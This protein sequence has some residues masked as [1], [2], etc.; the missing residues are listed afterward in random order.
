MD[1]A[2]NRMIL[3]KINK[4]QDQILKNNHD[5]WMCMKDV[6]KYTKLS[7]STIRRAIKKGC[8]KVSRK[9]GKNLFQKSWINQWLGDNNEL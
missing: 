9:T 4:I 3:K 8:L 5:E 6:V 7:D 2:L 1:V